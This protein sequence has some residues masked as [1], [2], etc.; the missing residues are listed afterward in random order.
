VWLLDWKW[1]AGCPSGGRPV[2]VKARSEVTVRRVA[3]GVENA[4]GDAIRALRILDTPANGL[5]HLQAVAQLN[6]A[7]ILPSAEPRPLRPAHQAAD[8]M[9]GAHPSCA[10]NAVPAGRAVLIR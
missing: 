2:A 4:N 9:L 1:A 8:A 6:V 10:R 3:T 7:A 5:I